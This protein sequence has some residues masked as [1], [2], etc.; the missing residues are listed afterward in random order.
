MMAMDERMIVVTAMRR[1]ATLQDAPLAVSVITAEEEDLGDLKLFRVPGRVDVSAKGMKQVAF[2]N[3]EEVTAR[4]LYQTGCDPWGWIDDEV[5]PEP[6]TL[7][8]VTKNEA[9]RGLGI[10]LPQGLMTLYEPTARGP[11]LAGT[12]DMRD[13]ARGQDIE[14]AMGV[15]SQVFAQCAAASEDAD[16]DDPRK[17]TQMR[18]RLTNANPHPITVRLQLGWAGEYDIRFP[19]KEVVIKNGYQTVEVTVPANQTRTFDWKLRDATSE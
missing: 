5:E 13:Y 6:T 10:A 12:A 19:R 16:P 3:K 1:Q 15:S 14:L 4:F 9:A 2:L 17:W 18:A 7:L 11:Q 8:L